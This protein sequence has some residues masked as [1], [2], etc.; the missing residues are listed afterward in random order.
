MEKRNIRNGEKVRIFNDRGAIIIPCRINP[1]IMPGVVDIPQGAWWKP[2][3]NG[4]DVGGC[5][6]TLTSHRWTPYA[7]GNA[8][9]TIMVEIEKA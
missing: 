9:L 1:K 7:F 8:Q 2:D 6:N 3:E 5:V 4:D